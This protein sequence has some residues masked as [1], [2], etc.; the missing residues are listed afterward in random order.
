MREATLL[1][2]L[3]DLQLLIGEVTAAAEGLLFPSA[4]SE[5][6]QPCMGPDV[7]RGRDES[8]G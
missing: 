8:E 6:P 3:R 4:D 5:A 1:L 2:L 7:D